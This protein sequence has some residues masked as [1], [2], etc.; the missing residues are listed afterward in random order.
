MD[1]VPFYRFTLRRLFVDGM[2]TDFVRADLD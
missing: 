1:G 2:L